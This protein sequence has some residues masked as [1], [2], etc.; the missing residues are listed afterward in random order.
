M[1]AVSEGLAGLQGVRHLNMAGAGSATAMVT[2]DVRADAADAV[3][4]TLERLGVTSDDIVLTRLEQIA[5]VPEET[6]AVRARLGR[7]ARPGDSPGPCS[8]RYLLLMAAAGVVG[9]FAVINSSPV[10]IVGAMAISPDLLPI[11]AACTGIALLRPRLVRRGLTSLFLGLGVSGL[12]GAAVAG[13][14]DV[15]DDLPPGFALSEIP[16]SQTHVGASTIAV[17]LAAGVAG[18]LAFETRASAAVGVAISVTT[19]PAVAYLGVAVG[20]GEGGK[21]LSALGVLAVNVAMMLI[22]GT[23]TLAG[24]RAI[25]ARAGARP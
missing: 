7:R 25:A 16:A 20:I 3:L 21:A 5:D 9:A 14:L 2:A 13:L 4:A 24:Q 18:I 8:G 12:V 17:A 11:M 10:L 22:G 23:V 1:A 19:I 6:G 15:F